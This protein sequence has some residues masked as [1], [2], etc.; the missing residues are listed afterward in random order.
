[1]REK[2]GIMTSFDRERRAIVLGTDRDTFYRLGAT[3][4]S[5]VDR[6]TGWG[7]KF[8]TYKDAGLPRDLMHTNSKNFGPRLGFAYRLGD[9]ARSLVIRGGYRISY[10]AIPVRFWS[11]T[12]RGNAPLTARF[13]NSLT[14]SAQSP[15]RIGNYG[16]R[17]APTMFAGV[18]S[19]NA[20]QLDN[21]VSLYRGAAGSNY[22]AP[23]QPDPLVHDWNFTLERE[24]MAN[25]VARVAWVANHG[26]RLEQVYR[27]NDNPPDYVWFVTTGLR[28]PSGD[29]SDV[30][31]RPYDQ[32]VYGGLAEWRKTGWSNYGG[33]QVELERRYS[34]GFGFQLF[35]VV[36]NTLA[37]GGRNWSGTSVIPELNQ[38]LPGLVPQDRE[39]RNRFLNYQRD[40]SI[41]K[42]RVRWN[43]IAD[44]PFGAGKPLGGNA[45]R[46][47]DRLIGGWQ[48]AGMGS[49]RGAYFTLPTGI[50]PTGEK[51]EM[52]GYKHPI[53]DCRG[54]TCYPGYLWWN[55]YIPANQINS[56]DSAGRPN[57]VMGVPANYKPSGQPIN[58]WPRNPNRNDPMYSYYGGNTVWVTLKDGTSQRTTFN[59]GLHP[60]R[61]QY[62]PSTRQWGLDASLFK[63]IPIT[64]KVNLRF[65]ADVFNVLNHPGNP[66][67]VGSDGILSTRSSGYGARE[68]QFTLRLSW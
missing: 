15:D 8:V 48:L 7:A 3:L 30:A 63:R 39:Q 18:N 35:Y 50:F 57:G 45:G 23:N 46:W 61:Q 54:G 44:L 59:N 9:G 2:N 55:G 56:T 17:S 6:Y 34:R 25:T 47:L 4:P 60:W 33:V 42:H 62:F 65:N 14:S 24:V 26:S 67:G 49:L 16:M 31:R 19:R 36:G 38:F 5:I 53:Q 22:F 64:E 51:I 68:M 1:L 13:S 58:P 27:Y 29:F 41:P 21:P 40:T 43:W 32:Q 37:A 10:F 52:Y 20:V 28:I 66:S 11:A 12:M